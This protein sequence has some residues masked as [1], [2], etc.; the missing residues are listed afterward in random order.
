[1]R[2]KVKVK[3]VILMNIKMHPIQKSILWW[4]KK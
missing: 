2:K 4:V 1:M 3:K